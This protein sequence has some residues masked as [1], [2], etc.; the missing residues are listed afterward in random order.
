VHLTKTVTE[1]GCAGNR[2]ERPP[3]FLAVNFKLCLCV[4]PVKK[5]VFPM[6]AFRAGRVGATVGAIFV[7][8][9]C[10]LP[11]GAAFAEPSDSGS[12]SSSESGD[13]G[14]ESASKPSNTGSDSSP[15]SGNSVS[16]GP[17]SEPNTGVSN[18]P[19]RVGPNP[20]DEDIAKA[21][22]AE[23]KAWQDVENT[24]AD[25]DARTFD[26]FASMSDGPEKTALQET[27]ARMS[28]DQ[29]VINAAARADE[30]AAL[31]LLRLHEPQAVSEA[32][33]GQ[34]ATA[35]PQAQ[36]LAAQHLNSK[37]AIIGAVGDRKKAVELIQARPIFAG[38]VAQAGLSGLEGSLVVVSP[39][40]YD[41]VMGDF[42]RVDSDASYNE[43]A[44][45][46]QVADQVNE[47]IALSATLRDQM[48]E[49][50]WAT[51]SRLEA[52]GR[53]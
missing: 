40:D 8:L 47:M 30:K 44:I 15:E 22:D 45:N 24:A 5:E 13:S 23:D 4:I 9:A 6:P 36:A 11:P 29:R 49:S 34:G 26:A 46:A 27:F 38:A 28:A 53:D 10:G 2:P 19:T 14:S 52:L 25:V 18:T 1:S 48:L 51:S 50:T 12:D 17:N 16:N 39:A 41:R 33:S 35:T 43:E 37:K 21:E 32:I 31:E 20:S 7:G 42:H 3:N